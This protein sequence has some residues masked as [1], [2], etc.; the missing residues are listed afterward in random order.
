MDILG[1]SF[2][3]RGKGNTNRLRQA[4]YEIIN[5]SQWKTLDRMKT[6]NKPLFVDEVGTTAVRYDGEY[7]Q[8]KSIEVYQTETTRKDERLDSL[9]D[10]LENESGIIGSI[11]FN[12]DLTY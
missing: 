11:Y 6:F 3:N 5:N 7:N 4:P 12:V 9:H 8:Q 1:V 2:Y 10:F